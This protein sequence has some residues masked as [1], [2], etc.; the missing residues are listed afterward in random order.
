VHANIIYLLPSGPS[1]DAFKQIT[2]L[3]RED[4]SVNF[5]RSWSDYKSGF[6]FRQG[7]F[8]LGLDCLHQIT[9]TRSYG[10]RAEFADFEG[11]SYWSWYSRFSVGSEAGGYRL[12]VSGYNCS[13]SGGDILSYNNNQRFTTYDADNDRASYNCA[14]S[15]KG[16][17][18]HKYCTLA[19]PTGLYL[20]GGQVDYRGITWSSAKSSSYCFKSMRLTLTP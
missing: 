5:T 1:H 18:W 16:G 13:S 8:W 3:N 15:R 12:T 14:A 17:W 19:N 9:S 11:R 7:E 20:S 6:G 10:L 4:G 2:F